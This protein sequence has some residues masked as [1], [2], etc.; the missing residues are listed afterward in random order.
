VRSHHHHHHPAFHDDGGLS[1]E[2]ENDH[3]HEDIDEPEDDEGDEHPSH[4]IL[5]PAGITDHHPPIASPVA[6]TPSTPTALGAAKTP[7]SLKPPSPSGLIPKI[8]PKR[9][10]SASGGES[11]SA[12]GGAVSSPA[13]G[14]AAPPPSSSS[15]MST[16]G[17]KKRFRHWSSKKADYNF[18]ADNDILG[19]VILEVQGATDLP[20]LSNSKSPR[21]RPFMPVFIVL[22]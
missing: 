17:K 1:S 21:T 22:Q 2:D 13:S 14:V 7:I 20:R 12:P 18:S 6:M 3:E 19:I 8:F 10:S 4:I 16:T 15:S 5:P 11:T 9:S